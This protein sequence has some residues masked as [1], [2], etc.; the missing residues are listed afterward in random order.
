MSPSSCAVQA[1]C[2]LPFTCL[3]FAQRRD[4]TW[5]VQ[6]D[7]CMDIILHVPLDAP[8]AYLAPSMVMAII[9]MV[10]RRPH[11]MG[12]S[13]VGTFDR[14][15]TLEG[16]PTLNQ[17]YLIH[18]E[19][20]HLD[21]VALSTANADSIKASL[22]ANGTDIDNFGVQLVGCQNMMEVIK[23]LALDQLPR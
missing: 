7:G 21:K 23:F 2:V 16:Y 13:V 3:C 6:R 5:K 1:V 18:A 19:E 22:K 11:T 12:C 8:A 10:W 17:N 9:N 15:G 4:G 20:L 14:K